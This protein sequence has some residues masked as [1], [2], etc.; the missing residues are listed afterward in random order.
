MD[1]L[2]LVL[3]LVTGSVLVGSLVTTVLALGLYSWLPLAVAIACGICL[4]WPAAHVISKM[5]KRN[6]PAWPPNGRR[7]DNDATESPPA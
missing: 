1:R 5:I 7:D 6:D 2:S 4:A 3:T